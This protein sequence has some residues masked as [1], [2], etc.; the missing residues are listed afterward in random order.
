MNPVF[1]HDPRRGPDLHSR[2]SLEGNPALDKDWSTTTIEYVEDGATKLKD[3]AVHSGRLRA[4]RRPVQEAVPRAQERRRR[5]SAPRSTSIC[6]PPSAKARRRSSGRSTTMKR[7]IKVEVH[8]TLVH[9]VEERRQNWRTLQYLAGFDVAKLD[10][11]HNI[12]LEALRHQYQEAVDQRETSIDSIAKAMSRARGFVQRAAGGRPG[13]GPSARGAGG[14]GRSGPGR[15][16]DQ[17][18][19]AAATPKRTSSSAATARPAIRNCRSCSRRE[20]G[21]RRRG[22][23]GG[24][25]HPRRARASVKVTPELQSQDRTRRRQL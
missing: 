5:R 18:R 10:A 15:G 12:E 24:S 21:R 2:F 9:L 20:G 16:E 11:D 1:V 23:G 14:A 4:D 3:V 19:G 17:R 6:P 8:E 7:L 25:P 22:E 13:A